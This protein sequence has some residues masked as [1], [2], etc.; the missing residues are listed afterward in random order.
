LFIAGS[1]IFIPGTF[2]ISRTI[3]AK[4]NHT[5]IFSFLNDPG[6]WGKWWPGKAINEGQNLNLEYD[7][8]QFKINNTLYNGFQITIKNKQLSDTTILYLVPVGTDSISIVWKGSFHIGSNPSYRAINFYKARRLSN[9]INLILNTFK[10]FISNKQNIYG[11]D[12]REEKV[13]IEYLVSTKKSF[14]RYPQPSDIYEMINNVKNYIN[15]FQAKEDDYPMLHIKAVDNLSYEVQIGIP[16]NRELPQQGAFLSKRM[17]R[18][19]DILVADIRGGKNV[20]DSAMKKIEQYAAD[21]RFFNI[22]L[23]FQ[24]L[25]TDRSKEKDSTKWITK[26]YYPVR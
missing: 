24:S 5:A 20:Y 2:Q 13:K 11:F 17:L 26:I 8:H 16:V 14:S 22:A 1:Y 6:N 18:N 15:Q 7:G 4:S 19:G 10:T 23:P 21:H 25:I 9:D 12:I 3:T